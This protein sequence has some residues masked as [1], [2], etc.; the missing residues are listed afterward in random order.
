M[1]EKSKARSALFSE[2]EAVG[3]PQAPR[4]KNAPEL[5]TQRETK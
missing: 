2:R 4:R 1:T 5:Q 3:T